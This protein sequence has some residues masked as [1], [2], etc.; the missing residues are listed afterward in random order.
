MTKL[1]ALSESTGGLLL[2]LD[3]DNAADSLK[4]AMQIIRDRYIVDFP[5]PAVKAA[6]GVQVLRYPASTTVTT[7][8]APPATASRLSDRTAVLNHLN[9]HM[10]SRIAQQYY[11]TG[12]SL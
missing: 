10:Q 1:A 12:S 7:S 5:R 9:K 2:A 8:S 6:P 3:N 11:T 4:R